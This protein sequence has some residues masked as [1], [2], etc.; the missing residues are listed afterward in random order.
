MC[1]RGVAGDEVKE[2]KVELASKGKELASVAVLEEEL[3]TKNQQVKQ[4]KK[5]GDSYKAEL[6]KSQA[7]LQQVDM[8]SACYYGW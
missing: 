7:A 5:Q 6:E 4:Y 3:Q 1:T 2:K 8:T